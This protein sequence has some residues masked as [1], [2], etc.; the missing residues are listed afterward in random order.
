MI[1]D[2][3]SYDVDTRNELCE[4]IDELESEIEQ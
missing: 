3:G 2:N 4:F 1:W